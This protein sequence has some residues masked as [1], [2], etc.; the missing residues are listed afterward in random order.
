MEDTFPMVQS[1]EEHSARAQGGSCER[2]Q[3]CSGASYRMDTIALAQSSANKLVAVAAHLLADSARLK[4]VGQTCYD[5][6]D[7]NL[8]HEQA[9]LE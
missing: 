3:T 5:I 4:E 8:E 6:C 9:D 7:S 1:L 2:V